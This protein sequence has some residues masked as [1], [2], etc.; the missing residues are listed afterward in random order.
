MLRENPF[1]LSDCFDL[2]IFLKFKPVHHISVRTNKPV[3][4]IA[5]CWSIR[6]HSDSYFLLPV[7]HNVHLNLF[8]PSTLHYKSSP[9]LLGVTWVT[10]GG[11]VVVGRGQFGIGSICVNPKLAVSAYFF[12]ACPSPVPLS[13]FLTR[14]NPKDL[15]LAGT[16]AISQTSSSS[17]LSAP[18]AF[19]RPT[20]RSEQASGV[21][22]MMG[23]QLQ[24]PRHSALLY[25]TWKMLRFLLWKP[26]IYNLHVS[27]TTRRHFSYS[28]IV[29]SVLERRTFQLDPASVAGM[30][31]YNH[32]LYSAYIKP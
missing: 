22:R 1:V 25:Y 2:P 32:I 8:I 15:K 31:V 18:T 13:H 20:S 14:G 27:M 7:V 4:H 28:K 30:R 19:T 12:F 10:L 11:E 26:V 16:S 29:T 17:T 6:C 21:K 5:I 24:F 23:T 9:R 3:L